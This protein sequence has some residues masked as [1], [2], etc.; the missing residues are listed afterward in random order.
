MNQCVKCLESWGFDDYVC[1]CCNRA[2]VDMY[3]RGKPTLRY[4][5][6]NNDDGSFTYDVIRI[7]TGKSVFDEP[8]NYQNKK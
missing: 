1:P 3:Y 5:I 2:T 8:D 7:S 4:D 6:F